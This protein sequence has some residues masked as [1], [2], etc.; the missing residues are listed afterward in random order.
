MPDLSNIKV[1]KFCEEDIP[2]MVEIWNEVIEAGN[3]FPEIEKYSIEE[4]RDF[5]SSQT[6]SGVAKDIKSGKIYGVYDQHPN[7]SGRSSHIANGSYAVAK[8]ARGL[9]IG[10]MLVRDSIERARENGFKVLQFNA[11]VKSNIG[12]WKLYEKIGFE[13]VGM[14]RGGFKNKDDQYEDMYIYAYYLD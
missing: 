13:R 2:S 8:D 10:E 1:V 3:A 7:L 5:F 9:H 11:V 12:A 14:I 6:Y 4:A